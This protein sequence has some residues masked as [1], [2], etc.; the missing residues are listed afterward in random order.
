MRVGKPGAG[1]KPYEEWDVLSGPLDEILKRLEAIERRLARLEAETPSRRGQPEASNAADFGSV[2][3]SGKS[4]AV[5]ATLTP[6]SNEPSPIAVAATAPTPTAPATAPAKVAVGDEPK[7]YSSTATAPS[8]ERL[9]PL[10]KERAA[11]DDPF[12]DLSMLDEK[13]E[14]KKGP[15]E[16]LDV[17]A[18]IEDLPRISTRIQQLWGSP[19]CEGYINNLVID[20]RGNRK[21]FPPAVMEELLYLG[22]LARALVILGIDGDIWDTFDQVG[23]RR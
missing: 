6:P 12:P 10:S 19:E 16:K 3:P 17:R 21:G 2:A 8:T 7:S 14:Q 11:A 4:Q 18:A 23:D 13:V 9:H 22:R 1:S 5:P 15:A 20:T